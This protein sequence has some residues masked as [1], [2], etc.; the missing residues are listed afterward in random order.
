MAS[1]SEFVS[2]LLRAKRAT[3][4]SGAASIGS[5]RPA[6]TDLR[7]ATGDYLYLDT[8]LGSRDFI[9][10]EA[11]WYRGNP[12]WGM[13]Y[14]GLMLVDSIPDGFSEILHAA[15][16]AVPSEAPFRGPA[17]FNLGDFRYTCHW[18]GN[19]E[20]FDGQECIEHRGRPIYELIFHGGKIS[21]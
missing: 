13:N 16:F 2:F 17:E 19:L 12:V 1:E 20:R 9:G 14:H 10:E 8:Y 4:A 5:S 7:Y 11:V 15:L 6:S 21:T 3:Y 18:Q